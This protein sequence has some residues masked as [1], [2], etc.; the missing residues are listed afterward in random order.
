MCPLYH[1]DLPAAERPQF[2]YLSITHR[3]RV[4]KRTFGVPLPVVGKANGSLLVVFCTKR[5]RGK[6]HSSGALGILA[7]DRGISSSRNPIHMPPQP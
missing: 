6:L 2:E 5:E 7:Q 3:V 4:I 1:P